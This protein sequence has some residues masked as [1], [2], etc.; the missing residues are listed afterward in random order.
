MPPQRSTLLLIL[1]VTMPLALLAWLGTYLIR[2]AERRTDA[3]M[4]AILA[5]R[6]SVANHQIVNDLRQLTDR[7]DSWAP[8]T[9]QPS[10]ATVLRRHP[11]VT[12]TWETTSDG[13]VLRATKRDNQP[14]A[15]ADWGNLL[16][17][18][19]PLLESLSDVPPA[20]VQ[21]PEAAVAE[22]KP[23]A[24]VPEDGHKAAPD[25]LEDPEAGDKVYQKTVGYHLGDSAEAA[26]TDLFSSGLQHIHQYFLYWRRLQDGSNRPVEWNSPP[27]W[28]SSSTN[29]E[30]GCP[31]LKKSRKPRAGSQSPWARGR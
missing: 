16:K 10:V 28:A 25:D 4:Q 26:Q 6:L 2:D 17:E 31:D 29:G 3:A 27:A 12:T 19:R 21:P 15:E 22:N 30:R 18:I 23:F 7:L 1:L 13:E 5:E 9:D 14:V 20:I 11:W 24:P 8:A